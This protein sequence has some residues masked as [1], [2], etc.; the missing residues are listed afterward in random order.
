MNYVPLQLKTKKFSG[1][2]QKL[3]NCITLMSVQSDDKER[4]RKIREIW[5]KIIELTG[6][7]NTKDFVKNT[8]DDDGRCTQNYRLC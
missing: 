5:S 3:K 7:N 1:E 4:F 6:I 2:I 8:I